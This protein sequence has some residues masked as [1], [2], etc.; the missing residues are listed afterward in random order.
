MWRHP[1]HQTRHSGTPFLRLL[2]NMQLSFTL[3]FAEACS[4]AAKFQIKCF[5][6]FRCQLF[7]ASWTSPVREG[8]IFCVCNMS[9]AGIEIQ[10]HDFHCF[11]AIAR[12]AG[13]FGTC[14]FQGYLNFVGNVFKTNAFAAWAF[15]FQLH[16]FYVFVGFTRSCYRNQWKRIRF[17]PRDVQSVRFDFL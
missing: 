6:R 15:L 9:P 16:V 11:F 12:S 5:W 14:D 1:K 13:P 3:L 17:A 2:L 8:H 4:A 10:P 7:S